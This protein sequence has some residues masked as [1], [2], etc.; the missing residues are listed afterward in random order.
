MLRT[1][2]YIF[3]LIS[4]VSIA[5]AQVRGDLVVSRLEALPDA[6]GRV[7]AKVSVTVSNACRGSHA[8]ASFVLVTFKESDRPGSK[9]VYFVG[10]KLKALA[11]G[12]S[13]TLNF[14]PTSSGKEILVSNYV[15]AEVDPY[16][17]VVE[18]DELN[19]WRS[20]NPANAPAAGQ[21]CSGRSKR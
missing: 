18:T 1:V 5:S 14:E 2:V 19:N 6:T 11:G 9:A 20:L 16:R 15:I 7:I 12:E 3:L 10:S 17:K 8:A 4:S 21:G 13:Q